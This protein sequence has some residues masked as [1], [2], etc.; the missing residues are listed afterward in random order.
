MLDV[1]GAE[2]GFTARVPHGTRASWRPMTRSRA[3]ATPRTMVL[4][5]NDSRSPPLLWRS[6]HPSSSSA[7]ARAE[8]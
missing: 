8:G 3:A 2:P 6:S 4:M 5:A 7:R 1:P